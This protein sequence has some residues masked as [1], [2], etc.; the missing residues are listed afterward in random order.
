[1]LK[2]N[3]KDIGMIITIATPFILTILIYLFAI[4]KVDKEIENYQAYPAVP[5]F[6]GYDE[7][8][9]SKSNHI[10]YAD[11]GL[12]NFEPTKTSDLIAYCD[13]EIDSCVTY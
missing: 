7:E 4:R 10:A 1:M 9:L 12:K 8:L 2:L 6:T 5:L 11:A 3:K 13:E